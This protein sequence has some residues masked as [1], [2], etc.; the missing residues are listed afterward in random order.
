M[1]IFF[2][3]ARIPVGFDAHITEVLCLGLFSMVT[4]VHKMFPMLGSKISEVFLLIHCYRVSYSDDLK[5]G[6][7][8]LKKMI[9][10]ISMNSTVV[11]CSLVPENYFSVFL[12]LYSKKQ[13]VGQR[14]P[15]Q[16]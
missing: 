3:V 4:W 8:L 7:L 11:G 2:F 5:C 6:K 14:G 16:F 9:I 13:F 10:L 15:V 1:G 12:F